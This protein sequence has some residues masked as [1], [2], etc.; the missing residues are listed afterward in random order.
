MCC[1]DEV[2]VSSDFATALNSVSS[3]PTCSNPTRAITSARVPS[4]MA[5]FPPQ[6]IVGSISVTSAGLG[7]AADGFAPPPID[8]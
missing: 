1:E 5:V 6:D 8:S 2:S 7:R 4:S 3:S